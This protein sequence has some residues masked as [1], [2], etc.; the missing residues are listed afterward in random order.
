MARIERSDPGNPTN[1]GIQQTVS[2]D[3]TSLRVS[4]DIVVESGAISSGTFDVRNLYENTVHTDLTGSG[5]FDVTIPFNGSTNDVRIFC[6]SD[7]I[8]F[9]VDNVKITNP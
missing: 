7:D 4:G 1:V 5:H 8:V 6:Y 3:Y 2:S 9:Y